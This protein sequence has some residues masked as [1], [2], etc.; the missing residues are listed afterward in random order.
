MRVNQGGW[1]RCLVVSIATLSGCGEE[2]FN[3]EPPPRADADPQ[4]FVRHVP[5]EE[6]ETK[7]EEQG[8]V[9]LRRAGEE[10]KKGETP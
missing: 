9:P 10:G 8:E 5:V 4:G 7:L 2:S 1:G 3:E 6:Q